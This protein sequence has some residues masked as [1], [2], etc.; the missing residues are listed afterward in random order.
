MSQFDSDALWG[1]VRALVIDGLDDNRRRLVARTG[2]PF[3]RIRA[4]RRL[5]PGPL[6]HAAL[7][8]A[9]MVDRPAAS[10]AVDDLCARGLAIRKAHPTDRRSKL[11]SLTAEGKRMAELI[12]TVAVPAP[13]GW[14]ELSEADLAVLAKVMG[15]LGRHAAAVPGEL[16]DDHLTATGR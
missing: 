3:S 5:R 15:K 4:L 13:P 9:M 12:R 11:V 8:E 2:L 16:S 7:A 10:V 6:T 14:S 1:A